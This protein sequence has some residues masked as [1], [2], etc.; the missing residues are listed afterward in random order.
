MFSS[1]IVLSLLFVTVVVTL[2]VS[3]VGTEDPDMQYALDVL[4]GRLLGVHTPLWTVDQLVSLI[5]G[6]TS[7]HLSIGLPALAFMFVY[8]YS[9]GI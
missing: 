7:N 9:S 1:Y 4:Y 5:V 3:C 6:V 8:S 2:S